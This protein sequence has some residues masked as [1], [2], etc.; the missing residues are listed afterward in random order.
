MGVQAILEHGN[1]G[2]GTLPTW[3]AK[4][5]PSTGR[6]YQIQ[7]S[8]RV[9]EAARDA[10]APFA[11]VTWFK[12]ETEVS[13]APVG[14]FSDLEARCDE[15]RRSGD[16]F[17]A[18]RLGWHFKR[19]STRAVNPP[20]PGTRFVDAAKAQSESTFADIDSSLVGLFRNSA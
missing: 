15:F 9:A 12:P 2:L 13:I 20:R 16:I 3:T 7:G 11:V 14:S 8:G 17:S 5:S 10:D 19:V 18:P 1:F 4:W 6:V